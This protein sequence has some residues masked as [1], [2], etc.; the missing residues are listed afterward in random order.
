MGKPE[1]GWVPGMMLRDITGIVDDS[2]DDRCH[3]RG[4]FLVLWVER[5]GR[6]VR[7]GRGQQSHTAVWG[8]ALDRRGAVIAVVVRGLSHA[9]RARV[10]KLESCGPARRAPCP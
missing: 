8:A 2:L 1:V 7:W 4:P 6:T 9:E 3:E 10:I 5:A